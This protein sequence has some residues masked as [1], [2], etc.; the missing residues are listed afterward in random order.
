MTDIMDLLS[1]SGYKSDPQSPLTQEHHQQLGSF[2]LGDPA[3]PTPPT[4]DSSFPPESSAMAEARAR[5][6]QN[7]NDLQPNSPQY[8]NSEN[9]PEGGEYDSRL[10]SLPHNFC[11]FLDFECST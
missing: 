6:Y 8:H 2:Y 4:R 10:T 7:N 5:C 11:C 1:S 3:T 9:Q